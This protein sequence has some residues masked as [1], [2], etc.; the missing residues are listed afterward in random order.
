[1]MKQYTIFLDPD[2]EDGGYTVT[3]PALPGI[4]T[5]GRTV[6]EAIVMARDAIDLHL[7]GLCAAGEP[8][9][10]ETI[11]PQAITLDISVPVPASVS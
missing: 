1:M 3:V 6:E 8:I 7:K 5:E 2:F 10:D 11:R 4:V 9:P